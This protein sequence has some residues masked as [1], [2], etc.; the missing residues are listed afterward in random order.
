MGIKGRKGNDKIICDKLIVRKDISGDKIA[1]STTVF[2]IMGTASDIIRI[3]NGLTSLTEFKQWLSQNPITVQ[4]QLK[5][6][7]T[8]TINPT[9]TDQDGATQTKL[10]SFNDGHLSVSS[11]GLLPSAVNYEV[12]TNNSYYLPDMLTLGAQYT[13]RGSA[14]CN[15]TIDGKLLAL[16]KNRTFTTP[17]SVTNRLMVLDTV[18]DDLMFIKGDQTAKDF[19]YFEGMKSV[20][21]SNKMPVLTTVGKNLFDGNIIGNY[22]IGG[23]G[24]LVSISDCYATDYIEIESDTNYCIN[25]PENE[26]T[27]FYDKDKNFISS[28]QSKT[29]LSPSNA[30]FLRTTIKPLSLLDTFQL[31][32]G[33]TT[34]PYEPYKSNILSTP[35]DLELRGIG[36]VRDELNCLMGELIQNIGE[37]VLDGNGFYVESQ[38]DLT[39]T[40]T[41][42]ENPVILQANKF[43][44]NRFSNVIYVNGTIRVIVNKSEFKSIDDFKENLLTNNLIILFAKSQKSIK[45]VDLTIVDQDGQPTELKTFNDI[46]HVEIKA[47]NVIPSVDV[48]VA[49]KISETL[50]ML[51]PQ[52]L[53][54][55][56]T[57]NQLGQTIDEQSEN[58]DATMMATTEI[59]EQTL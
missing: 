39:F 16:G 5:N 28:V 1:S 52:Q 29:F 27:G 9:I 56:N 13:A 17:S 31:E 55:S 32:E 25:T 6:K 19:G 57:Q 33:T 4:Y 41:K 46:T 40:F 15:A 37:V 30:R 26:I 53:D 43:L 59:Y 48:E 23:N 7:S 14:D 11:Q 21:L 44:S 36:D 49:T 45:T 50:A 2:G 54:I 20:G 34:T 35:S 51:D 8:K 3:K 10:H 22:Y 24:E 47:D 38:D 12:P 58:T 42:D 18:V